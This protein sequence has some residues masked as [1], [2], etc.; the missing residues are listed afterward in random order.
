MKKIISLVAALAV[1]MSAF[2]SLATVAS[3]ETAPRIVV[4]ATEIDFADAAYSAYAGGPCDWR[5][6]C[7][8]DYTYKTYEVEV[9]LT[10]IELSS[11][12]Y[13]P[14]KVFLYRGT[15]LI[16]AMANF[17]IDTEGDKDDTWTTS[18]NGF[19]Y[20]LIP[21]STNV[22]NETIL[23]SNGVSASAIYP[24]AGTETG[25]T[26][27]D[28]DEIT[29]WRALVTVDV[30]VPLTLNLTRAGATIATYTEDMT[31]AT[32]DSTVE[33]D[34]IKGNFPVAGVSLTLPLA[35][36]VTTYTYTFKTYDGASDIAS[37][38]INA[39]ET[40]TAPTAPSRTGYTF[41]GWATSAGGSTVAV[42]ATATAD[43]TYYAV[44]T[45]DPVPVTA[46]NLNKANLALKVGGSETLVATVDPSDADVK[47]VI[48]S[49]SDATVATVTDAGVVTAVG[50]GTATI[51][52][53]STENA[54]KKAEC[55]V[56]VKPADQAIEA[57]DTA[58][59]AVDK[60]D[61]SKTYTDLAGK[62]VTMSKNY[63]IAKFEPTVNTSI[64]NY[65]LFVRDTL[66]VEEEFD[67]NFAE[68]GVE[69][70]DVKVSFFAIVKSATHIVEFMELRARAK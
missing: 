39:G 47:T 20:N 64:M 41:S 35:P 60:E 37:A 15:S 53:A 22:A 36:S 16:T 66:G 3:A 55:A 33:Y 61:T 48:W 31:K 49:T 40:V 29:I 70:P 65:Y 69:A 23:G 38:A 32:P 13:K 8:E 5:E 44:Y 27:T 46:V 7:D 50:V 58:I 11:E 14:K 19:T 54:E 1:S 43:T 6:Y 21:G 59:G 2:V 51:T 26:V 63:G 25:V 28:T 34:T 10:G 18:P 45:K 62:A 68:L 9:K 52:V 17:T 42:D 24:A 57:K 12:K 67:V 30:E 4:S 56:S